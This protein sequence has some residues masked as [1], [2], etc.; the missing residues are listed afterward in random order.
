MYIS[1]CCR[2]GVNCIYNAGVCTYIC[3]SMMYLCCTYSCFVY[4]LVWRTIGWE[5]TKPVVYL[6]LMPSGEINAIMIH[7]TI[8]LSYLTLQVAWT[9]TTY[10]NLSLAGQVACISISVVALEEVA[11]IPLVVLDFPS[12]L[13][14]EFEKKQMKQYLPVFFTRPFKMYETACSFQRKIWSLIT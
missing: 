6:V 5:I 7:D 4:C 13:V 3:V 2:S 10:S 1:I 8:I 11:M 9:P 14:E 12:S